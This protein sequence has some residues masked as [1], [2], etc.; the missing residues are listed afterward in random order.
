LTPCFEWFVSPMGHCLLLLQPYT[1][2]NPE[3]DK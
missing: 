2:F 1:S 3:L